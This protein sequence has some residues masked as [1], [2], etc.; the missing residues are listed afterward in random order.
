VAEAR[1]MADER[2]AE[3]EEAPEPAATGSVAE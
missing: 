3:A 1:K 2:A